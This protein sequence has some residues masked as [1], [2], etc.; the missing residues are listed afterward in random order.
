MPPGVDTYKAASPGEYIGM[1]TVKN[2]L[3]EAV[4]YAGTGPPEPLTVT[5][6][7][8][9]VTTKLPPLIIIELPPIVD[10]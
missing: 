5:V 7:A 10:P 6:A 4:M 2:A 8:A 9:P 3:F 1:L